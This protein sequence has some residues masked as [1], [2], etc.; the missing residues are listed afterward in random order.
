MGESFC[1]TELT[2]DVQMILACVLLVISILLIGDAIRKFWK[3]RGTHNSHVTKV[4]VT[5]LA[6]WGS[7]SFPYLAFVAT[8]VYEIIIF[9]LS[10][11]EPE[12]Y[13]DGEMELLTK[14]AFVMSW[15]NAYCIQ[16]VLLYLPYHW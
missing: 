1:F 3:M 11:G 10:E 13:P 7:T 9:V 6:W 14:Y 12:E 2:T 16:S 5:I 4:Y 8:N 15:I